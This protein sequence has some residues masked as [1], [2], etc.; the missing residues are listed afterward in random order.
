MVDVLMRLAA[1]AA[2]EIWRLAMSLTDFVNDLPQ[3][4]FTKLAAAV[5]ARQDREGNPLA[6]TLSE[7]D[8]YCE[9]STRM[10]AVHAYRSRTGLGLFE[11]KKALDAARNERRAQNGEAHA[12]PV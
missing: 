3:K 8:D 6:P 12:Q 7:V 1:D 11:V 10:N 2:V 9:R 5:K 4:A